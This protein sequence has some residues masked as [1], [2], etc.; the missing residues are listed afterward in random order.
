MI[1]RVDQD[2]LR[3]LNYIL[4]IILQPLVEYTTI[5]FDALITDI[6]LKLQYRIYSFS[7]NFLCVSY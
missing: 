4:N 3:I 7:I 1:Y 2:I 6:F 5:Y